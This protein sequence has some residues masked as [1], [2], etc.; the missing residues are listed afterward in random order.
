MRTN[1]E[2]LR[3]LRNRILEVNSYI[4]E[5]ELYLNDGD[6][7]LVNQYLKALGEMV[8][9]VQREGDSQMRDDMERTANLS[10]EAKAV[11]RALKLHDQLVD[12]FRSAIQG[13]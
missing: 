5:K 11:A 2:G 6:H 10:R 3:G 9:W 13:S 12:R 4:L 7:D 1:S 8:S